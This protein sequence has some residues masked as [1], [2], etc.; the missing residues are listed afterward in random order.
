[1]TDHK[2]GSFRFRD[3][4][5]S[6]SLKNSSDYE[7]QVLCVTCNKVFK[8]KSMKKHVETHDRREE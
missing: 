4:E 3:V 7:P 5:V 8:L 2:F 6:E 1:M